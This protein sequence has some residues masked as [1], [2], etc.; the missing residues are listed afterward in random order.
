MVL[1]VQLYLLLSLDRN[2]HNIL[3]QGGKG[4]MTFYLPFKFKFK[5]TTGTFL[6]FMK[7]PF[8]ANKTVSEKTAILI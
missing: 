3:K 7:L 2:V 4:Q 8:T 1:T 5:V 6:V